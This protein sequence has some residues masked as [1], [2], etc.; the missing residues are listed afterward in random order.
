M[1]SGNP[2]ISGPA[3]VPGG[4]ARCLLGLM[5]SLCLAGCLLPQDEAVFPD[6]PPRRNTPPRVVT[7]A[8]PDLVTSVF[9]GTTCVNTTFSLSVEE[10]DTADTLKSQ[11][12]IDRKASSPSY[13]GAS[14][15]GPATQRDVEAPASLLL[16]L[17][18][19]LDAQRHLVE[20]FITDSEFT[21][22]VGEATRAPVTLPDGGVV[23]DIGYV[24]TKAWFVEVKPCE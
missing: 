22:T 18:S 13:P 12:F 4:L 6:L 10:L 17:G 7:Y 2:P 11:W 1:S 3:R 24:V 20:A 8:P 15:L 5:A 19:L 9:V 14:V 23:V 16:G 21:E